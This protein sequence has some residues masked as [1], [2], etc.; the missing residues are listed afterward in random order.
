MDGNVIGK[1]IMVPD[2]Q[3]GQLCLSTSVTTK[4]SEFSPHPVPPFLLLLFSIC[5]I[6]LWIQNICSNKQFPIYRLRKP[7]NFVSWHI[8]FRK[9]DV[10]K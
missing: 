4:D 8:S 9:E 3:P 1:K 2:S 6:T 7:I 5:S 10:D